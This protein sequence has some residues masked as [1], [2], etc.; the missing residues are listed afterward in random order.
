MTQDQAVDH[1]FYQRVALAVITSAIT[2]AKAGSMT[3]REW[4]TSE[5]VGLWAQGAGMEPEYIRRIVPC[6]WEGEPAKK[7]RSATAQTKERPKRGPK[8]GKLTKK[9]R[10]FIR[11]Y[12]E[13]GDELTAK[14][15]AEVSLST[16]RIWLKKPHIVELMHN[17]ESID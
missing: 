10:R 12:R 16:M 2:D 5:H 3:A 9:Q 7:I 13:H 4:L 14:F 17:S 1:R 11:A 6:A 15:R 8:K